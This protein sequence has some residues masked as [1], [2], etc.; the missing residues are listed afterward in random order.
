MCVGAVDEDYEKPGYTNW[1]PE[2]AI[3]APGSEILS[4]SR[5]SDRDFVYKTGTS[6][7][8]PIVAGFMAT[9]VGYEGLKSDTALVYQRVKQNLAAGLVSGFPADTTTDLLN[10]GITN[11]N[12]HPKAPYF[13]AGP[14]GFPLSPA[15]GGDPA[16]PSPSSNVTDTVGP[17]ATG[18]PLL[19][20]IK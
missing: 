13:G 10:I 15:Q 8:T 3:L 18:K 14:F 16:Q 11:P 9:I 7:A 1:G 6:M 2:L 5:D 12:R 20:D 19:H 4:A 17:T